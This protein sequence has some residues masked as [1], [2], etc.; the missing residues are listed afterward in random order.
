M[1]IEENIRQIVREE[2]ERLQREIRQLL[3]VVSGHSAPGDL[4]TTTQAARLVGRTSK[5]VRRWVETGLLANHGEGVRI[6]VKPDE[7][8]QAARLA[9]QKKTRAAKSATI[10]SEIER[11]TRRH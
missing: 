7:V 4:L 10:S 6:L 2:G 8:R 11:L 5:T 1:S 9:S 3:S